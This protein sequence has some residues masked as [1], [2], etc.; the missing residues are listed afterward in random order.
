MHKK[1]II[2]AGGENDPNIQCLIETLQNKQLLQLE[3]NSQQTFE[4]LP[5]LFGK[6]S[7]PQLTLEFLN[8]TH[9]ELH[10]ELHN[11]I[12]NE[13]PQIQ[14]KINNN[15][16]NNSLISGCFLRYD[17]FNWLIDK[18]PQV[19]ARATNFHEFFSA[20]LLSTPKTLWCPNKKKLLTQTN[21]FHALMVAQS[22]GLRI[23]LTICSNHITEI[24]TFAS[25]FKLI[26]SRKLL[27]NL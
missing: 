5:I 14:L 10:N 13:T 6:H 18:R 21:K 24:N 9:N 16:L 23:P 25:K 1:I 19:S 3:Q 4:L 26:K 22:I 2:I 17:V 15:I 11:E 20:W 12:H 8:T 7:T 27:L